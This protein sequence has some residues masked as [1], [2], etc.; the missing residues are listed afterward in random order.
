MVGVCVCVCVCVWVW[1]WVLVWE[2]VRVRFG[3]R[4]RVRLRLRLSVRR[5]VELPLRVWLHW[6]VLDRP[7]L[8]SHVVVHLGA[9]VSACKKRL[10]ERLSLTLQLH[11]AVRC[12]PGVA[13]PN[14]G[15]TYYGE[16]G[17]LEVLRCQV[18]NR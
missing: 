1:V 12:P 7:R 10:Y 17:D 5:A 15:Y 6:R 18:T 14:Y 2:G 11:A 16:Y 8:R 9:V 3:V 13:T 4:V